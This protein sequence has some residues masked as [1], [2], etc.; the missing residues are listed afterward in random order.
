[1]RDAVRLFLDEWELSRL[2]RREIKKVPRLLKTLPARL[3]LGCG[4]N[5]KDGWVNIDL[6][7]SAADLRLDLRE[8]WPFPD[9]SISYIYSEH[10]FEHFD[11]HNEVPR[12][13]GEAL[14]VLQPDGIFDLAVPDTEPALKAYDN[15]GAPYWSTAA[16]EWH[17]DWCET[18]LDHI[19][20]H[21][22]QYDEFSE[23][24][25]HKYAWDAKTLERTL[26]AAG[27]TSIS[28]RDF[29]P[30][31]DSEA[32]RVGSLYMMARKP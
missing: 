18:Q 15:P 32:R 31:L 1:M 14:R 21:F 2:H 27:F 30:L 10:L 25:Q 19:N 7:D 9:S 11:F 5:R 24:D 17:P 13:L 29:N 16:E 12:F 22:R 23:R 20:Y 4:P 26:Q 28:Q 8:P 3:N 6:F